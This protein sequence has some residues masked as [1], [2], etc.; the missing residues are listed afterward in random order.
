MSL[1]RRKP[2]GD[3][4][5][6]RFQA[7]L[8]AHYAKRKPDVSHLGTPDNPIAEY[9]LES[10][11]DYWHSESGE[12][13]GPPS[14]TI[15]L[16]ASV[17]KP[18]RDGKVVTD[19]PAI[20]RGNLEV[21][22]GALRKIPATVGQI[23]VITNPST[24]MAFAA[25][26][27]RPD[28]PGAV[29]ACHAGT[30]TTRQRARVID[31]DRPDTYFTLGPHEKEQVNVD[32]EAREGQGAIDEAIPTM[33]GDIT[34]RSGGQAATVTTGLASLN[35]AYDIYTGKPGSYAVPLTAP[36]AE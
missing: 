1:V 10:L 4:G 29:V 34:R 36:E 8:D 30:D 7:A 9:G 26:L 13:E 11:P 21:M 23:Q 22:V 18:V 24:E 17:P 32:L 27:L 16:T 12:A 19:R 31:P 2:A 35:E 3:P 33:G 28:L 20:M 14:K 6:P 15:F 5:D 25:W